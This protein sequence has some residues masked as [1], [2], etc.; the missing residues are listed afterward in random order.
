MV[1]IVAEAIPEKGPS[2]PAGG[3]KCFDLG[4]GGNN[5]KGIKIHLVIHLRLVHITIS[6]LCLSGRGL[7]PSPKDKR[8]KASRDYFS[9]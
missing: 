4:K 8:T 7:S 6:T 2:E 3:S 1:S 9:L 5:Y